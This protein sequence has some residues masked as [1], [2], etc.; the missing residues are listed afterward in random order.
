[1]L[2]RDKSKVF[3]EKASKKM[4]KRRSR[5]QRRNFKYLIETSKQKAFSEAAD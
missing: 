2:R 5:I 4:K 1:M 3:N